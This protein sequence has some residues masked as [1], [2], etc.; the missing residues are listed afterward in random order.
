MSDTLLHAI[1]NWTEAENPSAF[2][3]MN[4]DKEVFTLPGTEGVVLYRRAGGYLVQFGGPFAPEDSYGALVAA[5]RAHARDQGLRVVGVQLQAYDAERYVRHGFTV[6]QIGASWAVG[7]PEFSLRGTRFMQLRNKI[8]RALRNGL[9]VEEVAAEGRHDAIERIDRAWLKSKG[10]NVR[11]LEFLVGRIG[12]PAQQHRRL[13]L[14]TIDEEPVAYI[15]YSPV[16]GS[17]SGWMHDLSR[18]LPDGSPGLMEAVNAAAIEIFRGEGAEWLH[19]GFTP[20]TGL[21]PDAELPGHSPAFSW[22]M[23]FLWAEG[24]ALYP[25]QTQLAYKEKWGPE[26]LI[27]EYV[28]FEG[29]ASLPS[30]AHIFRACNSF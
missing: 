15:S 25:A 16:Y 6:N 19:F 23:Q 29:Q 3:A 18:R 14:G 7:L 20:F 24:A 1:K 9:K 4:D 27:P 5:F 21:S 28:A 8:S 30:F 11:P 12:G 17:R 22:L 2:L 26:L 13:F 10:E